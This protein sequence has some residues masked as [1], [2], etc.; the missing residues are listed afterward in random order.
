MDGILTPFDASPSIEQAQA[1]QGDS[2]G[3]V[4]VS[5]GNTSITRTDG[6]KTPAKVGDQIFQGDTVETDADGAIGILFSDDSVF[7]LAEDGHMVIDEMIYDPGTQEGSAN[8]NIAAGVFTFVS[9]QIAKTGVDSMIVITPTATIG[10]RGTAGAVRIGKNGPDTYTLLEEGG[11]SP[12]AIQGQAAGDTLLAQAAGGGQGSFGEMIITNGVGFQALS[13]PNQTTQVNGPFSPPTLPIILPASAVLQAYASATGALPPSPVILN[14]NSGNNANDGGGSNSAPGDGTPEAGAGPEGGATEIEAEVAAQTAAADAFEEALAGGASLEDAMGAAAGAATESR[15]DTALAANPDVFGTSGSIESVMDAV[16]SVSMGGFGTDAGDPLDAGRGNDGAIDEARQE[17]EDVIDEII[18]GIIEDALNDAQ[19]ATEQIMGEMIADGLLSA[20][21]L[22]ASQ[23]LY[24]SL[25]GSDLFDFGGGSDDAFLSG[26][27]DGGFGAHDP[28]SGP[29]GFFDFASSDPFFDPFGDPFGDPFDDPFDDPFNEDD[30]FIDPQQP[31]GNSSVN[32]STSGL[33]SFTF[34]TGQD[35]IIVNDTSDTNTSVSLFGGAEVGD[36][37]QGG[38]NNDTLVF[39]EDIDQ[40]LTVSGV[41]TIDLSIFTSGIFVD[42]FFEGAGSTTINTGS[43]STG[44][45]LVI[46]DTTGDDQNWTINGGVDGF[47]NSLAIFGGGGTDKVTFAST[48]TNDISHLSGVETVDMG[49]GTLVL[50]NDQTGVT[51]DATSGSHLTLGGS[52]NSI[53]ISGGSVVDT[54]T[55]SGGSDTVFLGAGGVTLTNVEGIA[56]ITGDGGDDIVTVIDA[57]NTSIDGGAGND[58]LTGGNGADV[59]TGGTGN[60]TFIYST[61]SQFG[62][63][64]TDFETGS[65]NDILDFNVAVSAGTGFEQ[66]ASGTV[67]GTTGVLAYIGSLTGVTAADEGDILTAL[68]SLTFGTGDSMLIAVGTAAPNSSLW[69]WEDGVGGA[70][71]GTIEAGEFTL[72][73]E[74]DTADVN[75]LNADNFQGFT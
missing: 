64:I 54:L 60:D 56:S 49:D 17:I 71:D 73:T 74:L 35:D 47:N 10:I 14:Q 75:Q 18:D 8:F 62:D 32:I 50:Q 21:I 19:D 15:I 46:S 65:L 13:Q 5:K 11:N 70:S 7:S 31:T 59:L 48:T 4:E 33:S 66:L 53:T 16:F 3:V 24:A 68:N 29:D 22:A 39:S 51:F 2:I 12:A 28:F 72:V 25:Q 9:G 44:G 57:T 37:Y 52:S 36:F 67:A 45:D 41:T 40:S 61:T 26:G 20:D 1:P 27:F 34:V 43:P 30:F 6:T 23:A 63:T 42:L 69:Y 58:T 38:S 55:G